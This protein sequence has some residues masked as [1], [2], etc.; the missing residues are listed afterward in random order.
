MSK[1]QLFNNNN[2]NKNIETLRHCSKFME[3]LAHDFISKS[4]KQKRR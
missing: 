3:K 2:N 1:T 4:E